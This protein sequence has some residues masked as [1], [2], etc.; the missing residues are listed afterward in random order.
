M[1]KSWEHASWLTYLLCWY[2]QVCHSFV[3]RL[4]ANRA[5]VELHHRPSGQARDDGSQQK[6]WCSTLDDPK[7]GP[8]L[9]KD[10][11]D[12]TEGMECAARITRIPGITHRDVLKVLAEVDANA[13][14]ARLLKS[15]HVVYPIV[16]LW[17][18]L[19]GRF[20]V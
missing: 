3:T 11:F 5:C 18:V 4:F 14:H 1:D 12:E 17:Y 10:L 7:R 20:A 13:E 19:R 8:Q 16:A 15:P 9:W 6:R 2:P